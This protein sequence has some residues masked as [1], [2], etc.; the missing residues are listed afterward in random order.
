MEPQ[1]LSIN[2]RDAFFTPEIYKSLG[3]DGVRFNVI[4][5][6]LVSYVNH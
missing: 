6:A 5:K 3:H 4:K 1:L 2:E